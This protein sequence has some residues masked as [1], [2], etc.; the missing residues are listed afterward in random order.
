MRCLLSFGTHCQRLTVT[1]YL[2]WSLLYVHTSIHR[3]VTATRFK[4]LKYWSP[5]SVRRNTKLFKTS[6][7]LV[8][9]QLTYCMTYF[10]YEF[11]KNVFIF[12]L[13]FSFFFFHLLAFNC[14]WVYNRLTLIYI[15]C[16]NSRKQVRC[17]K[18]HWINI[19]IS[20]LCKIFWHLHWFYVAF[21]LSK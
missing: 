4:N 13:I 5:S 2:F 6:N 12:C 21:S 18:F 1:K 17:Y 7:F 11:K 19:N 14:F 20:S 16:V 10:S 15:K 8:W 9:R 3:R